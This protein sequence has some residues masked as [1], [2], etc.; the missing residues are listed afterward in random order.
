MRPFHSPLV[1]C[2]FA[3][4]LQAIS[5]STDSDGITSWHELPRYYAQA[6]S[7][8]A[9]QCRQ[10]AT[11]TPTQVCVTHCAISAQ[12]GFSSARVILHLPP[13]LPSPICSAVGVRVPL[14]DASRDVDACCDRGYAFAVPL[15]RSHPNRLS[16]AVCVSV[17]VRHTRCDTIRFPD[18]DVDAGQYHHIHRH[19]AAVRKPDRLTGLLRYKEPHAHAHADAVTDV[20]PGAL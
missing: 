3:L 14:D 20:E 5:D 10:T 11:N 19:A 6:L 1:F 9:S 13:C 8:V 17:S 16:F 2:L 15:R 7:A 12:I 4:V 18:A